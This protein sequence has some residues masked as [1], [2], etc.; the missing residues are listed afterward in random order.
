MS[1]RLTHITVYEDLVRIYECTPQIEMLLAPVSKQYDT[2]LIGSG[3]RGN[4]KFIIPIMKMCKD[5]WE[6]VKDDPEVQTLLVNATGWL[7]YRAADRR[8][9]VVSI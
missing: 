6:E 8:L 5:R 7:T 4:H 9:K 1:E 3:T 2:G